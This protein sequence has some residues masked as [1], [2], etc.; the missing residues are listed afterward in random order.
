VNFKIP[1]PTRLLSV[2]DKTKGK[3]DAAAVDEETAAGNGPQQAANRGNPSLSESRDLLK[4][5]LNKTL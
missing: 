4:K 1:R 5:F 3:G 2:N